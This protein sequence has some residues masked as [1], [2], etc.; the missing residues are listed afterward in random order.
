MGEGQARFCNRKAVLN[1]GCND[2]LDV[3]G[4]M[5]LNADA[6]GGLSRS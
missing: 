6:L 4:C 1:E 3:F 2:V 5:L